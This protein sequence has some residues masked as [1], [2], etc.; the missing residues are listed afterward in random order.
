[1]KI[2]IGCGEKLRKGYIH[3]DIR[4]VKGV[5]YVC[6]ANNLPFKDNSVDEIYTRHLIEH[7]TFKEFLSTLQEW[8][9]VL[10]IRGRLYIICPNLIW[11]LKQIIN[12]NH[13]SF[14]EK[15]P[16]KNNHRYWGFGSLFGWQQ[17]KYDVH[18]FGYYFELLRDILEEFGFDKIKNLTDKSKSLEKTPWHLEVEAIKM[19]KSKNHKKTKFYSLFDVKH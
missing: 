3:C 17:D 1:M 9:R 12:S 4:K 10:K 11:H 7:F 6:K 15:I 14:Y 13:K 19:K 18:K 8:N 16:G 2:E 5:D